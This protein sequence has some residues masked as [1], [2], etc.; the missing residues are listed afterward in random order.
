MRSPRLLAPLAL[1]SWLAACASSGSGAAGEPAGAD[2]DLAVQDLAAD[3]ER[4]PDPSV[5]TLPFTAAEI[6]GGCAPG[7]V[8]IQRITS[9]GAPAVLRTTRFVRGD[10]QQVVMEATTT[11]E[12]GTPAG[13]P[14]EVQSA[15]TELRD[16]ARFPAAMTTRSRATCEV[17]A[18]AFDCWLYTVDRS[19]EDGAVV[20]RL[21][22]A[23]AHPGPPVLFETE[24]DGRVV[25]RM[26]LVELRRE[27]PQG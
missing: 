16:H 11:L 19:G 8:M 21:Y 7:T 6:R 25:M 10:E 20:D 12:D 5:A 3:A 22:F 18:G 15:W 9:E 1:L 23:P 13:P 17:P 24:R 27:E 4:N 14:Q 2:R 26:E